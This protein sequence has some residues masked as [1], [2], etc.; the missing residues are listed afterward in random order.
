MAAPS[1]RG[2]GR[3]QASQRVIRHNDTGTLFP[4]SDHCSRH[5][6]L[7]AVAADHATVGRRRRA[8]SR[9]FGERNATGRQ[10]ERYTIYQKLTDGMASL[11]NGQSPL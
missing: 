5:G 2:I 7:Y 4:P 3:R 9:A 6:A 8:R 11:N 10:L 1:G